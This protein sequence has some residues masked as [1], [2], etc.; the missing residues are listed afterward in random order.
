MVSESISVALGARPH[1]TRMDTLDVPEVFE[2]P[3]HG[4]NESPIKG[5]GANSNILQH[6]TG[7]RL[8]HEKKETDSFLL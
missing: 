2:M 1:S 3:Q 5:V 8:I 4:P 7:H 6:T